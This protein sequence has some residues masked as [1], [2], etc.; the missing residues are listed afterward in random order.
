[1]PKFRNA[2]ISVVVFMSLVLML[3][4][5]TLSPTHSVPARQ[6]V[7]VVNTT[8]EPVPTVAQGSTT[9]TG[10]VGA[11]QVGTWLLGASQVGTW[12][13]DVARN[14]E[15]PARQPFHARGI[16]SLGEGEPDQGVTD[17]IP[18]GKRFV[19][20]HVSA[21]LGVPDG[22]KVIFSVAGRVDSNLLRHSLVAEEQGVFPQVL[23]LGAKAVFV[24]SQ[25]LRFYADPGTEIHME[26]AR[27]NNTGTAAGE[28][29]V[30]GHLVDIP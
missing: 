20:E 28:M 5:A 8:E 18:P 23:G 29:N 14:A 25:P 27:T 15:N 10:N 21:F 11:S 17:D 6:D 26:V 16:F 9:V 13:V 3:V 4:L 22:Q 19:F 7:R 24:A 1:M 12:V 30:S 2:P